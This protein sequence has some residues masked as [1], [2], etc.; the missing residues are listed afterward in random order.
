MGRAQ[1][2]PRGLLVLVVLCAF[3]PIAARPAAA[4]S[5]AAAIDQPTWSLSTG[6]YAP[7]WFGQSAT[8]YWGNDAAQSGG[9]S[10]N[11][12]CSMEATVTGPGT[13]TFYWKVSSQAGHDYL[14]FYIDGVLRTQ[15]SGSLDWNKKAFN[16]GS[17]SHKLRWRYGKNGSVSSGSDCGWVDHVGWVTLAEAIDQ[18][19]WSVTT[20]GSTP[21]SAQTLTYYSGYDA[22]QSGKISD[23][24]SSWMKTTVWVSAS[25]PG[26][27]KFYWKL[28]SEA[29]HDYLEFYL[30]GV[31]KDRIS[32]SVAWTFSSFSFS[33]GSHMLKWQ[34][35]KNGSASSG[36][37]CGWVDYVR[38]GLSSGVGETEAPVR[39]NEAR[40]ADAGPDQ[41]LIAGQETVLSGTGSRDPDGQIV[42]YEWDLD[43]DGAFEVTGGEVRH[44]FWSPGDFA[45]TLRVTD[46]AGATDTDVAVFKVVSPQ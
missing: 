45:V 16:I 19:S 9:I 32:G 8:Y 18:P 13:V 2:A 5:L 28:S 15:I 37:D 43:G 14:G 22:A 38:V 42:L 24:Q 26:F 11:Q 1:G 30:D 23:G 21:W 39:A 34:Y 6:G 4:M 31:R 17:G 10:H 7:Q 44:T 3:A 33:S 25:Q 41:Q 20:G 36:S 46:D 35:I 29:G 27:V 40:V 12:Y